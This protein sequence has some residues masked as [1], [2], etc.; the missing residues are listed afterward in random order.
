MRFRP[1]TAQD[2]PLISETAVQLEFEKRVVSE[3]NVIQS[4]SPAAVGIDSTKLNVY[5]AR[6]PFVQ[7][8]GVT[9]KDPI[10]PIVDI[11]IENKLAV[12]IVNELE[13]VV[14]TV[15]DPEV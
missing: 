14:V 13:S 2:I 9:A 7:F 10:E 12:S 3:G 5:E 6:A 8:E 1:L 15:N 4:L 11:V